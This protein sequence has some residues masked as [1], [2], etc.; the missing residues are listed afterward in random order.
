MKP[1][2]L[3]SSWMKTIQGRQVLSLEYRT[4]F[5]VCKFSQRYLPCPKEIC[6]V[7]P[8]DSYEVLIQEANFHEHLAWGSGVCRQ[9]S[10][11]SMVEKGNWHCSNWCEEWIMAKS[12]AKQYAIAKLF[13]GLSQTDSNSALKQNI[14][15]QESLETNSKS[16][17]HSSVTKKAVLEN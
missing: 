1:I 11:L 5:N 17:K 6:V 13:W 8:S 14:K 16:R 10:R 4:V 12:N 2:L 7:F 9:M 3:S 15:Y